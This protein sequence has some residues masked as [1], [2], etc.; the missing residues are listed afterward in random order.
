[1]AKLLIVADLEGKG[2]ATSRGLNIAARTGMDSEVVA[3]VYA[4]LKA[5]QLATAERAK[6]KAQLIENRREEVQTEI[7]KRVANGQ[8]VKLRVVWEKDVASW[9][10]ARC[11][12]SRYDMM[13]KTGRRPETI[14]HT[15]TDWQL[16][17]ECSVPVLILAEKKWSRTKPV[18][19]ALHLDTKIPA[20]KKLNEE[21]LRRAKQLASAMDTTV[22][23]VSAIEIPVLLADLDLIDPGTYVADAKK[24]MAPHIKALAAQFDIP[25]KQFTVKRGPVEKVIAS[26]AAATRA[27]LV[28]MGTVGRQGVKARLLGNTAEK[29]LR[30]LKTDVLAI[31]P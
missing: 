13:I 7:D 11:E 4:P 19:A 5:L 26:Q 1:M 24:A 20:K 21:I 3:F 29:V 23:I 31:K 14:A 9:V 18:L 15:S 17:R 30:H 27:Q 16:L 8:K 2:I 22:E 28:I 10:A 12:G 6:I 25:Q